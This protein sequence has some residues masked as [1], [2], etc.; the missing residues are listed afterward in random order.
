MVSGRAEF[1]ELWQSYKRSEI[2][3]LTYAELIHYHA[4]SARTGRT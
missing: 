4:D 3:F 1:A 2:H